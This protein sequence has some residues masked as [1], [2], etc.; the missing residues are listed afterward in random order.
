MSATGCLPYLTV[1]G[2]AEAWGTNVTT[3]GEYARRTVDPLPVRYIG[4]KKRGGIV[5]VAEANEWLERNSRFAAEK[6]EAWQ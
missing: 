1:R 6:G 5:I 2:L 4:D 3:I